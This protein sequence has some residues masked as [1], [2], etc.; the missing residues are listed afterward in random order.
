M[1][2]NNISVCQTNSKGK[3]CC[4][5]KLKTRQAKF[6]NEILTTTNETKSA[7]ELIKAMPFDVDVTCLNPSKRAIHPRFNFWI[8]HSKGEVTIQGSVVLNSKNSLED[9]L[10]KLKN[11]IINVKKKSD[12]LK[13]DER[14][15]PQE[16]TCRQVDFILFGRYNP[17]FE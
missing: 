12:N 5:Q 9:N 16:E 14:L 7:E 15:T 4:P 17:Y 3:F 11:F 6:L 8:N 1:H 13:G 10:L 2:V